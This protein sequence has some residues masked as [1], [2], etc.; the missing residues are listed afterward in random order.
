ML[1]AIEFLAAI[2]LIQPWMESQVYNRLTG[3][4]TTVWD[5]IWLELRVNGE[6]K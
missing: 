1:A 4:N 5:A 6:P 3:A 2:A